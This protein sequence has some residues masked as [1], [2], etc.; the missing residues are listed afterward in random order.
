L[1]FRKAF[2]FRNDL[3]GV[4]A[5]A[6][7]VR[8]HES[9]V[10]D[11]A[12]QQLEFLVFNSGEKS[13]ADFRLARDLIERDSFGLARFFKASNKIGHVE[14]EDGGFP[15]ATAESGMESAWGGQLLLRCFCYGWVPGCGLRTR[16]LR[17]VGPL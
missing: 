12:R 1:N 3:I 10:E 8:P 14:P 16:C 7:R 11:S 6:L 5:H 17:T 2:V 4:Q 15:L 13:R 9:T